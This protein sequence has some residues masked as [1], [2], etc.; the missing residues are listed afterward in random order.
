MADSP[1]ARNSS[2]DA[3]QVH[4]EDLLGLSP[5]LVQEIDHR[6]EEDR[7][8]EVA[9]LIARLHY[10]DLA[11]L[12]QL[13]GHDRRERLIEQLRAR[14]DPEI[15][16]E[17]DDMV[18]DEGVEL[19][20]TEAV[21]T[22]IAKLES[23]DAL[24][25]ISTLEE[26]RQ[27]QVLQAI[28]GALRD[29]LEEGLA[30]PED[31]AGRLMQRDFVVVPAFWTVGETIDFLRESETLP[32]EF[33]DIFVVD[34][35]HRA[36]GKVALSLVLRNKRPVRIADIMVA[37]IVSVPV[38]MDQEEVAFIFSQQDLLSAPV[39]DDAGRLIGVITIDDVVDVI[40]EEAEEDIMHLGGVREDDLYAAVIDTGRSRFSWLFLNLLTAVLAS[41]VIGIF[42]DTIERLVILAVLMPIVASMG[43]NAGTQTLTVAVRALATRELTRS[44]ALR[45][46]SKEVL[47]GLFNGLL[48]AA[49][50][51]VIA[52]VW[53]GDVAIGA[54]MAVAM[55]VTMVVAG[56]VG[57]A[58]PIGLSRTRIDPA[59][60]S[61][62]ILTTVTDV[63]AFAVFLGLAAWLLL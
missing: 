42:A 34:P 43:G 2:P 12:L 44:N 50:I 52:W 13:L 51:G 41:I 59:I 26:T 18:R 38:T 57:A 11:D 47:V 48:F 25:L 54:V 24:N 5:D 45:V 58:I 16:P 1:R 15:L 62:V 33:F 36:V 49:L 53:S 63:V 14:F 27:H 29:I 55:I 19:L 23:D 9:R 17:L 39:V 20:G 4:A 46:L 8:E 6:L 21:A 28:S 31:S 37:G 3:A 22:A 32:N 40:H 35:R 7:A 30:F 61:S 10:A 56:L 60:A